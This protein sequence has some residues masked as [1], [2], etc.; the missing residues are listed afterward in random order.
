M[1]LRSGI[2]PQAIHKDE[3]TQIP[4]KIDEGDGTLTFVRNPRKITEEIDWS[5]VILTGIHGH[6]N[7]HPFNG[8]QCLVC[9]PGSPL[10]NQWAKVEVDIVNYKM[11]YIHFILH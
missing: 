4:N 2:T 8:N 3:K 10:C 11:R 6:E 9:S 7:E 1:M 5:D